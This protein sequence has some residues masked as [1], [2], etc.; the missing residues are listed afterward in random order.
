MLKITKSLLTISLVAALAIGGTMA[1]FS[2][3]ATSA[4]NSFHS[5]TLDLKLLN[6]GDSSYSDSVTGTF[7][8]SNMAP[9]DDQELAG[10]VYLKNTGTIAADHVRIISVVN[11]PS[12]N[13]VNEPECKTYGGEWKS[14]FSHGDCCVLPRTWA[15]STNC[16]SSYGGTWG[17]TKDTDGWHCYAEDTIGFKDG[18]GGW[19]DIDE[20]LEITSIKYADYQ[21]K[22][23]GGYRVIDYPDHALLDLNNNGYF[24]L[25]D[26]EKVANEEGDVLDDLAGLGPDAYKAFEMTVRLHSDADNHYQTDKN[27]IKITFQ[28]NQDTSQ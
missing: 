4:S 17:D 22:F 18:I 3:T 20:H 16:Q 28:L 11:T 8:V 24:D 15:T 25:D 13:G 10:K 26:L 21:L 12:D 27:G 6:S 9:G 1:Y 7:D 14:G 23:A 2:D 5:G 19:N